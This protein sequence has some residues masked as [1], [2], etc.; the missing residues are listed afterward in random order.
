MQGKKIQGINDIY[1]EVLIVLS[2]MSDEIVE[3]IPDQVF[4]ELN[5]LAADSKKDFYIDTS[6]DIDEQNISREAQNLISLIYYNYI[7]D[8]NEK[9]EIYNNWKENEKK[10]NEKL[11]EKYSLSNILENK[12]T[13]VEVN[14][15]TQLENIELVKKEEKG[16]FNKIKNFIKK[17]ITKNNLDTKEN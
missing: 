8:E 5:N 6:K 11:K 7:A 14:D 12:I 17:V 13:K 10:Y 15:E 2:N 16:I 4:D 9:K 3:K 1:K